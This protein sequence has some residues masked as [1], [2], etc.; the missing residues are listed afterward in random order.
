MVLTILIVREILYMQSSM[1]CIIFC[2]VTR[3]LSA[4]SPK[5]KNSV[6]YVLKNKKI[7]KILKHIKIVVIRYSNIT[8]E[9]MISMP[10]SKCQ[11]YLSKFGI[12]DV[13]YSTD[14]GEIVNKKICNMH[15]HHSRLERA[16]RRLIEISI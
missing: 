5:A 6:F 15:E 12:K 11:S 7:K 10:C 2:E 16:N 4:S 8:N 13:T 14:D 1:H 9:L 3:S